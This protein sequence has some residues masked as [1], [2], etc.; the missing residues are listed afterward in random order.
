MKCSKLLLPMF[1]PQ[2]LD[3]LLAHNA[4]ASL[5]VLFGSKNGSLWSLTDQAILFFFN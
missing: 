1:C 2:L 4:A 3:G 5:I